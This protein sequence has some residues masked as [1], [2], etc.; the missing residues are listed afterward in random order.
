ML[1]VDFVLLNEISAELEGLSKVLLTP[2]YILRQ[3]RL[4]QLASISRTSIV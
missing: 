4:P 2:I 3:C 1:K